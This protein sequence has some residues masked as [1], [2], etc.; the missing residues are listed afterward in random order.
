MIVL[1]LS[2]D[3][4]A[5]ILA[6]FEYA[7]LLACQGDRDGAR[8]HLELVL[9]GEYGAFLC[10]AGAICGWSAVGCCPSH[11]ERCSASLHVAEGVGKIFLGLLVC[12][13]LS[14]VVSA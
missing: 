2:A 7:R 12:S 14:D 5:F 6:D 10:W 1:L 9:S 4:V 13:V 8:V 11:G 3:V